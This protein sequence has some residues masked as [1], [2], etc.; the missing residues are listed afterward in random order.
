MSVLIFIE[1][2]YTNSVFGKFE[3]FSIK[4]TI[5]FSDNDSIRFIS[6]NKLD[7]NKPTVLWLRGSKPDPI[8]YTVDNNSFCFVEGLVEKKWLDKYNIIV[9]NKPGVN[10]VMPYEYAKNNSSNVFN[11]GVKFLKHS[12]KDYYVESNYAVL[13][14]L[15][16]RI[17]NSI[18]VVGHSQGYHVGVALVAKYPNCCDKLVCMSSGPLDRISGGLTLLT[19][20]LLNNNIDYELFVHKRDSM[21]NILKEYKN[22]YCE[23]IKNDSIDNIGFYR[24]RYNYSFNLEK[25]SLEYLITIKI[26]VLIVFGTSD[27]VSINNFLIESMLIKNDV[28]YKIISYFGYDHNYNKQLNS[29]KKEFNWM[30]VTNDVFNWLNE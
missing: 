19:S 18:Y 26:P 28:N 2:I 29:K 17:K 12:F 15:R 20:H 27:I 5:S 25:T 4:D 11:D 1:F 21:L 3:Y 14:F 16:E 23:Y 9:I 7:Y 10:M 30:N 13:S 6:V 8:I 22:T 24:A